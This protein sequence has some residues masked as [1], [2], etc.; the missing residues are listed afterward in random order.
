[1]KTS[2]KEM[3]AAMSKVYE[4]SENILDIV[5]SRAKSMNEDQ[6][7]NWIGIGMIAGCTEVCE[8]IVRK[9]ERESGIPMDWGY[10]GRRAFIYVPKDADIEKA[11]QEVGFALPTFN[12]SDWM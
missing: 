4:N 11:K 6:K 9:A 2:I 1:M 3:E 12:R 8:I 10:I 5:R 7:K